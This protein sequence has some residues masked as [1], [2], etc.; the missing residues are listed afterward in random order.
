MKILNCTL[1]HYFGFNPKEE[2]KKNGFSDATCR[3][4]YL[5]K[6]KATME[7][8][9]YSMIVYAAMSKKFFYKKWNFEKLNSS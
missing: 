4:V 1:F 8:V 2:F 3:F 6:M 7:C 9:T 5:C